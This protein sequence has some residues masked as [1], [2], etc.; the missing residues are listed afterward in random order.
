MEHSPPGSSVHGILRAR[1]L[2]WVII[3]L[4]RDLPDPGIEPVSPALVDSLITV[5]P[6]KEGTSAAEQGSANYWPWARS[7]PYLLL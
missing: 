1:I 4:S 5:P 6:G 2:E 3:S 7:F